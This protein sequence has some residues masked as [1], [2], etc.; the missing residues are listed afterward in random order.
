MSGMY[1]EDC[2]REGG[3]GVI[4]AELGN[5]SPLQLLLAL[6]LRRHAG[7]GRLSVSLWAS[8]EAVLCCCG[9]QI[10]PG[11]SGYCLCDEGMRVH[12]NCLAKP[13]RTRTRMPTS[14]RGPLLLLARLR[15]YRYCT[16]VPSAPPT[17]PTLVALA[18]QPPTR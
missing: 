1:E 17:H 12:I 2:A 7:Q 16:R 5:A 18:A 9:E 8:S 11:A 4:G 6:R 3:R 15:A 14:S 13:V 10:P